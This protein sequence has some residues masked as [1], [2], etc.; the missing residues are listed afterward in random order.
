MA[1]ITKR[2]CSST[3]AA[4]ATGSEALI[5]GLT[6]TILTGSGSIRVSGYL[7]LLCDSG[8]PAIGYAFLYVDGYAQNQEYPAST[9]PAS[10]HAI[11][12]FDFLVRP[13]A[14]THTFA[15]YGLASS[16]HLTIYGLLA[17]MIV[18]EPGY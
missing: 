7:H 12:P 5:P 6:A 13:G 3:N 11:I 4:L 2:V 14:G 17:T 1:Q 18:H 9:I 8:G 10:S 16:A 15:I